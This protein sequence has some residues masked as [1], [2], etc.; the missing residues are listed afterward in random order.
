MATA[1]R[2]TRGTPVACVMVVGRDRRD[3][4]VGHRDFRVERSELQVLLVFLG[5]VMTSSQ[6]EYHRILTLD[7]AQLSDR[8]RVVRQLVVGKHRTR[9]DVGSHACPYACAGARAPSTCNV[10]SFTASSGVL[11]RSRATM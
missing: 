7:L 8:L 1:R 3:L 2:P 10:A 5:T 4:R 6:G 9:N 11:P